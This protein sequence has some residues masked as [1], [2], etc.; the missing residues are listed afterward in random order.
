MGEPPDTRFHHE[1]SIP[2][3]DRTQLISRCQPHPLRTSYL[4]QALV[5]SAQ[6]SYRLNNP[7]V[8]WAYDFFMQR[9]LLFPKCSLW[10]ASPE[11]AWS[12]QTPLG[13]QAPHHSA[14]LAPFSPPKL[15]W[16]CVNSLLILS[17]PY[18]KRPL[19][20]LTENGHL[21]ME[22]DV[23]VWWC[24]GLRDVRSSFLGFYEWVQA[25]EADDGGK[26]RVETWGVRGQDQPKDWY[27]CI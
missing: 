7:D 21:P 23:K 11:K 10:Q 22:S 12:A 27:A 25:P 8:S 2:L 13:D 20:C 19:H 9:K 6:W 26:S 16:Q 15:P 18:E 3:L 17:W 24:R 5:F 14:G 4:P 1:T